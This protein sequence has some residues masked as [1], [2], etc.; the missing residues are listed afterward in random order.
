MCDKKIIICSINNYFP[1]DNTRIMDLIKIN[2]FFDDNAASIKWANNF[3]CLCGKNVHKHDATVMKLRVIFY[4]KTVYTV[5]YYNIKSSEVPTLG[6]WKQESISSELMDLSKL[7]RFKI[8]DGHLILIC[9]QLCAAI[10]DELLKIRGEIQDIDNENKNIKDALLFGNSNQIKETRY[11]CKTCN[12]SGR[13]HKLIYTMRSLF[14]KRNGI[15]VTY[16]SYNYVRH[17]ANKVYPRHRNCNEY[18][19]QNTHGW[20]IGDSYELSLTNGR[21]VCPHCNDSY[22]PAYHL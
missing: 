13:G 6:F 7:P 1:K 15:G 17:H 22:Y 19:S 21:V 16:E 20:R 14:V 4:P 12:I 8:D 5:K 11:Y 2:P 3:T 18:C 10:G 9:D